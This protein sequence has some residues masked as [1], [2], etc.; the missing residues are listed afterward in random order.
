MTT[1]LGT[2]ENRMNE[3]TTRKGSKMNLYIPEAESEIKQEAW[4][5]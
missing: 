4:R 5:D 1:K 2:V 3:K